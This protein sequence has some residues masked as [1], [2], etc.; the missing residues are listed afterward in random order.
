MIRHPSPLSATLRAS[1]NLLQNNLLKQGS[2]ISLVAAAFHAGTPSP[3]E[4]AEKTSTI[5]KFASGSFSAGP[6]RERSPFSRAPRLPVMKVDPKDALPA[7]GKYVISHGLHC[8]FTRNNTILTLVK[9]FRRVGKLA[10]NLSDEEKILDIVRPQQEVLVC[11]SAGHLGFRGSKKSSYE[12]SFQCTSK[13]FDEME[14]RGLLKTKIEIIFKDFGE[15]REAFTNVLNG[16]EGTKIRP[17][18]YRVTDHT[19][20]K[21]G[22]DRAPGK[23]RV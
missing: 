7:D 2:R 15:G 16:K 12:A 8:Q 22:G 5:S 23:R 11:I 17:L 13:L 21:F 10:E 4:T 1:A 3:Q 18:I 19:I 9:R 14:Q 6:F 20:V